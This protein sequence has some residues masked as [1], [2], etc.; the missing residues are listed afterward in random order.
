MNRTDNHPPTS[1]KDAVGYEIVAMEHYVVLLA[2][3]WFIYCED[4][5]GM[6]WCFDTE[7]WYEWGEVNINEG[8]WQMCRFAWRHFPTKVIGESG[9]MNK[10]QWDKGGF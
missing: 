4:Q 9:W 10:T 8:V 5:D 7:M 6:I 2:E 3:D 1:Q